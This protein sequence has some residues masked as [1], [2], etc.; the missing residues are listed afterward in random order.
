LY[1]LFCFAE[2]L[3]SSAS[4]TPK[5]SKETHNFMRI[6]KIIGPKFTLFEGIGL[7]VVL[8]LNYNH[9]TSSESFNRAFLYYTFCSI[10][11][12]SFH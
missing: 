1:K 9:V 11:M 6:K 3:K 7:G 4:K 10:A 8:S 5:N 12:F 2:G